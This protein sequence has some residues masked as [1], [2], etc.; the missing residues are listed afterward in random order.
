MKIVIIETLIWRPPSLSELTQM[1]F[2]TGLTQ[3]GSEALM[4][5]I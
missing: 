2:N 3:L 4:P 5:H 1:T